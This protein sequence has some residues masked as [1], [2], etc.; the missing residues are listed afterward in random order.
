MFVESYLIK[1][2]TNAQAF[3][4]YKRAEALRL[5]FKT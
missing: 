3:N 4:F 5:F 2:S 1:Y